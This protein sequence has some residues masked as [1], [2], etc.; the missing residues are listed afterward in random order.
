MAIDCEKLKLVLNKYLGVNIISDNFIDIENE[1]KYNISI[2][3]SKGKK[4]IDSTNNHTKSVF[5]MVRK[6]IYKVSS[7]EYNKKKIFNDTINE[8]YIKYAGL[9]KIILFYNNEQTYDGKYNDITELPT[10]DN[11]KRYNITF[12]ENQ[13][14]D[15][16]TEY[17]QYITDISFIKNISQGKI[18]LFINLSESI[19]C[20]T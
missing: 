7:D 4:V 18:D 6:D 3:F 17:N 2:K 10:G 20:H 12:I 1:I 14:L 19:V 5:L 8:H 9:Q 16:E 15:L 11:A 13:D